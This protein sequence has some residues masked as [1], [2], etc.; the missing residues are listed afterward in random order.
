MAQT[1]IPPNPVGKLFCLEDSYPPK[2]SPLLSAD[3]ES[4]SSHEL[5][6][7]WIEG[8]PAIWKGSFSIMIA[9]LSGVKGPRP[10][11]TCLTPP[12]SSPVL[13]QQSSCK[14]QEL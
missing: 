7:T 2:I 9:P 6:F 13:W 12:D 8:M 14:S 3:E 10:P 11:H 1:T 5:V 4:E